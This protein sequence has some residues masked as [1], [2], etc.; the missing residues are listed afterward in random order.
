M[1]AVAL[2]VLLLMVVV[3]CAGQQAPLARPDSDLESFRISVDVAL[4]VLHATVTDRQGGAVSTLGEQDF[5]VHEDGVAQQI[6]VFTNDDVPVTTA[7][8]CGL[9]W[10]RSR[11]RPGR[12]C[13]QVIRKTKCSSLISTNT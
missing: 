1:K 11:R 7:Q 13:S 6:R 5:E 9:S 3:G 4:V 2:L 8:A 12:S 10:R